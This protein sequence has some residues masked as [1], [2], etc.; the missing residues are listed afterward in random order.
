MIKL[1]HA[2]WFGRLVLVAAT[3]LFTMLGLRGLFDPVGSSAIHEITLG[4]AAGVTVARVA[5]GGFPFA[6]AIILLGCAVAERRLLTGL[7]LLMVVAIVL[8]AARLLGLGLDGAAPF[9]LRV[10]KP[11]VAMIVASTAAFL[12]ER[13]RRALVESDERGS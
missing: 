2:V 6:F 12:L 1:R 3:L 4:S 11:E 13:R 7:A 8:T 9:T 5:F 10:L